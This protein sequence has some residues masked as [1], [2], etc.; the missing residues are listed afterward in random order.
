[1]L[2]KYFKHVMNREA[3]KLIEEKTKFITKKE[4]GSEFKTV[5]FPLFCLI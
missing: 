5:P 2:W 4:N 1:M 3:R